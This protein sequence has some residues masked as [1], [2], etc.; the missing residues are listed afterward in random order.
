MNIH[1]MH[2]LWQNVVFKVL[3]SQIDNNETQVMR[4]MNMYR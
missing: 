2:Y 3:K 4:H 1:H